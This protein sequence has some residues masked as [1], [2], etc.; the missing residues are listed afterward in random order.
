MIRPVAEPTQ[1]VEILEPELLGGIATENAGQP[2]ARAWV[3]RA[4]L[5]GFICLSHMH[6]V[7]GYVRLPQFL[8]EPA[9]KLVI[10]D[11]SYSCMAIETVPMPGG[12]TYGPDKA[13]WV[14][15]DTG[16]GW[17]TW[18]DPDKPE[19]RLEHSHREHGI[20]LADIRGLLASPDD[21]VWTIEKVLEAVEQLA[22][23]ILEWASRR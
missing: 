12:L 18:L 2:L 5:P 22:A 21:P 13:G 16:H 4:G 11:D 10:V 14:G 8:I 7:N 3:T 9:G 6:G 20:S 19:D 17:D 1:H 15:F 23:D